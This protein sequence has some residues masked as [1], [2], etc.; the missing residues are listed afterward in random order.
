[1]IGALP[2]TIREHH[3]NLES[4]TSKGTAS[5][6]KHRSLRRMWALPNCRDSAPGIVSLPDNSS[7]S[8]VLF[9]D[10]TLWLIE[11]TVPAF[12]LLALLGVGPS[13]DPSER[14]W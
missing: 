10:Q 14:S 1:M 6:G 4:S 7:L 8:K 12:R 2:Q 11:A 13:N 5:D 9:K 3:R